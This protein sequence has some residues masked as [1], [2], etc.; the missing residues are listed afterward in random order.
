MTIRN[1]FLLSAMSVAA[2]AVGASAQA[3]TQAAPAQ[4]AP[5]QAGLAAGAQVRDT[6]GG[7][8]GTITKVDGQFVILKTDK[9]EVRLPVAS[10]TAHEGHFLM[11][12]TR[13]QLNAE[14]DKTKAAVSANLA[15]GATVVGSQGSTVGTVTAIDAQFVTLKLTSGKEVRLPRNAVAA[16]AT[17]GVIGMTAAELEAAAAGAGS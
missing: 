6:N 10:F 16:N 8:V 12:M 14:V 15:A 17:G 1:K 2:L 9:H 3:A 7:E 11:A 5:A 13:D 4:A